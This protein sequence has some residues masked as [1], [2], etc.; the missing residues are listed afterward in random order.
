MDEWPTG[1]SNL[2][3]YVSVYGEFT[4]NNCVIKGTPFV[5]PVTLDVDYEH[6]YDKY[7]ELAAD[8]KAKSICEHNFQCIIVENFC[9]S[10]MGGVR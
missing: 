3:G 10:R 6:M 2:S 1:I 7:K 9:S 5:V 4:P 8:L